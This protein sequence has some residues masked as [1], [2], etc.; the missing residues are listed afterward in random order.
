MQQ[1]GGVGGPQVGGPQPQ[2]GGGPQPQGGGQQP[3]GGGNFLTW[4]IEGNT[5][6]QNKV[7]KAA[8]NVGEGLLNALV[9]PLSPRWWSKARA[10]I[11][12]IKK[13]DYGTG[14]SARVFQVLGITSQVV[15]KVGTVASVLSLALGIA[16]AVLGP[17][18]G[19][20]AACALGS[21]VC[22]LIAF[23]ASCTAFILQSVLVFGNL[24]KQ[25]W[26][27]IKS[28]PDK[29][30]RF[31]GDLVGMIGSGLG[32]VGGGLGV[33]WGGGAGLFNSSS[34]SVLEQATQ[35]IATSGT[36]AN[37]AVT[38]SSSQGAL[39]GQ[40]FANFSMGQMAGTTGD[41][42]GESI[43]ALTRKYDP[44]AVVQ[45]EDESEGGE[46]EGG[47]PNPEELKSGVAGVLSA[48]SDSKS[49]DAKV[50]KDMQ[51][52]I[53][54][55]DKVTQNINKPMSAT[56][57]EPPKDGAPT[58][59]PIASG[60]AL[61]PGKVDQATQ[62]LD[63]IETET[64]QSKKYSKKDSAK[65]E[66]ADEEVKKAEGQMG[67][68]GEEPKKPGLFKRFKDWLVNKV[69]N[70]KNRIKK[71][72]Q[73]AKAKLVG[74]AMDVMGISEKFEDMKG[75]TGEDRQS[76]VETIQAADESTSAAT[77]AEEKAEEFASKL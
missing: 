26:S 52:S 40:Q 54:A 60:V 70:L 67:I 42:A 49:E 16:G 11:L 23:I 32:V 37:G 57:V 14:T 10:D 33:N 28:D 71:L 50:K 68:T 51:G 73:A 45:R 19:A 74:A 76:N 13:S 44:S 12:G 2:V 69:L 17:L 47:T 48:L 43:G 8:F 77:D 59:M 41:T 46:S 75:T 64:A 38:G 20:G 36:V 4:G 62:T 18:M 15:Q 1:G 6:I 63:T 25:G 53:A 21:A 24:I 3:Q 58:D 39:V 29:K 7:G 22:G 56:G 5:G 65:L 35:G 27:A 34:T 31:F 9:G 55:I 30:A 61:M 66:N 72:G